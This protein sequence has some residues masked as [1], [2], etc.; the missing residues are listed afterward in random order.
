MAKPRHGIVFPSTLLCLSIVGI[1]LLPGQSPY[2]FG[3][4]AAPATAAPQPAKTRTVVADLLMIDE[5]FYVVRGERGEIR[6]EVTTDTKLSESFTFGDRIK[7]ILL[8]NDEA[9]SITRAQAGEAIGVMT[10]EPAPEK[11]RPASPSATP[12][13]QAPV[14]SSQGQGSM[15]PSAASPKSSPPPTAFP[16]Q[17]RIIIAD[18]LMVDG[19]FY[20]VRTERGEI[21]IEVTP[22][23]QLAEKFTFGDRIKA[24]VTPNDRALSVVR[25]LPEEPSGIQREVPK[26]TAAPSQSQPVTSEATKPQEQNKLSPTQAPP[27]TPQGKVIIG[28]ILMVDGD[29]YVI[30]GERGEIRLEVTPQTKLSE[31]FGYGDRIKAVVLPNDKA[32]SIERAAQ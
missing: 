15:P 11:K 21:Q 24:V 30:R 28:D 3:G 6:I 25:A 23:T 29:F 16:T 13:A 32:L 18:L 22:A 9:L 26:A 1:A 10:N 20:I 19:N 14:A 2:V 8:P 31:K 12:P 4:E 7:A 5:N 27:A 17:N